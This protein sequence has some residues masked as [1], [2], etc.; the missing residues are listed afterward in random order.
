MTELE[1]ELGKRIDRVIYDFT[2]E[3]KV[4]VVSVKFEQTFIGF[5]NTMQPFYSCQTFVELNKT[6]P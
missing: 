6:E 5:T 2:H 4:E 3:N 1:A